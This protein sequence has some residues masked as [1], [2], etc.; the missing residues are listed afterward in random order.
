M[1]KD[2][3]QLCEQLK[4]DRQ[5]VHRL[6]INGNEYGLLIIDRGE[7]LFFQKGDHVLLCDVS[8]RFAKLM[9]SSVK[10]WS[11]GTPITGNAKKELLEEIAAAYQVAYIDELEIV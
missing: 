7:R 10:N 5:R 8:A 11:D 9:S 3:I 2:D 1:N 4:N 6:V